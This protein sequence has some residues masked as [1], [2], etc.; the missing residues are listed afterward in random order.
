MIANDFPDR[1]RPSTSVQ[2]AESWLLNM[3][4]EMQDPGSDSLLLGGSSTSSHS[5]N[6][7]IPDSSPTHFATLESLDVDILPDEIVENSDVMNDRSGALKSPFSDDDILPDLAPRLESTLESPLTDNILPDSPPQS[8]QNPGS[9]L[10]LDLMLDSPLDSPGPHL[11]VFNRSLASPFFD[12]ILPDSPLPTP[13]DNS[14]M[15]MIPEDPIYSHIVSH[16][17]MKLHAK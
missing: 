8:L 5:L 17:T 2:P 13:A 11:Q 1:N 9:P 4:T 12:D 3:D 10:F 6:D 7:I 16:L 15:D 14:I